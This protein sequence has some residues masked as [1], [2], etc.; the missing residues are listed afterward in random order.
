MKKIVLGLLVI[1]LLIFS[2]SAM[3][4]N[5]GYFQAQIGLDV[6]GDLDVNVDNFSESEDVETGV[7][8]I[9][10]YKV[11]MY[12]SQWTWGGGIT[13]Q[14][15]RA[16]DVD[17]GATDFNYTSFYGLAQ[18]EVSDNP[19]YIVG[20][21]GYNTLSVDV[22]IDVNYDESGGL[23]YGVGAGYNFG[24]DENYVFEI[25]YSVNNGELDVSGPDGTETIDLE[26]SKFT[27]SVGMKF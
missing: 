8:L 15:E 2:G 7:S 17:L 5:Q 4:Q 12:N 10:E 19:L 9:G 25:L 18:Y 21:L 14:L 24:E 13:Y 3:A 20:K 27:A 26:Y 6:F 22:P 11:P 16:E 1:S 23:Y